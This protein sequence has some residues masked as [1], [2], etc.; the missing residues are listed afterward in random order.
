MS[1]GNNGRLDQSS[2]NL[3]D[4]AAKATQILVNAAT[5]ADWDYFEIFLGFGDDMLPA[6]Q[7]SAVPAQE[8]KVPEGGFGKMPSK[9]LSRTSN[10]A[11][12]IA[13]WQSVPVTES[14]LKRW[15]KDPRYSVC[16][17]TSALRAL[18]C[19]VTDPQL[20]LEIAECIDAHLPAA[21]KRTRSNSPK[22]LVPFLYKAA[23][24]KQVIKTAAGKIELLADG[25][26]FIAA[27]VHPSG[28]RYE[29][30]PMPREFPTL[31]SELLD[32]LW[33]ALA[34]RFGVKPARALVTHEG[35]SPP[36]SAARTTSLNIE[37]LRRAVFLH[38]A[39]CEHD[40]W[41]K[42]GMRLH[43][44][45]GG[46]EDGLTI[47]DAWSRTA[48]RKDKDGNLVY[49]GLDHLRAR[50]LSFSSEGKRAVKGEALIAQLPAEATEFPVVSATNDA[51]AQIGEVPRANHLCTDLANA[52]RIK[53]VFGKRLISV[54]GIFY[55]W[56]GTHWAR[57][58]GE[59]RRCAA[60][61]S[62]IVKSEARKAREKYEELLAS[63]VELVKKAEEH[64]RKHGLETTDIGRKLINTQKG[65]EALESWGVRCEFK[66]TQDQAIGLLRNM[67]TVEPSSLDRDPWA[68]NCANGTIDLRTGALR[69]HSQTDYIT[70]CA[71]VAFS[72]S[73]EAP[74]FNRFLSEI[75]DA[76]TARIAFL[77]RW[78]G[79]CATGDVR[80]QKLIVHVGPGGNGKSTLLQAVSNV[81]GE[82]AGTAAPGLL[83]GSGGTDRHPTEIADLYGRRLVTSHESD[84]GAMLRE[85]FIKQATGDDSL[86]GRLMR[87]DF[88]QFKPTHKFQLLTNYKPIVRGQDRGMWRRLLLV[89][90]LV[91]FGSEED[92][93]EGRAMQQRDTSL[94]V[95]LQHESEGILAWLVCGAVE[96]FRDGLRAPDSVLAASKDYQA[97]QDRIAQFVDEQCARDESAWFPF[98][99]PFGI[100]PLYSQWSKDNGYTP[101][102]KIRFIQE[103]ERVVPRFRRFELKRSE[104]GVRK[105]IRGAYGL[106]LSSSENDLVPPQPTANDEILI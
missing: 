8:S 11:V 78:F 6:V 101:L 70:R 13:G 1:A 27:G 100:Y 7:A 30:R 87:A 77:R 60:K 23:L 40:E 64:P 53:A 67:L 14:D 85:G 82:Y 69:P 81:L 57:D 80:E 26:Q 25:E 31:S 48:T 89:P 63:N 9:Y 91:S 45:A 18:D 58:E 34:M 49:K 95:T 104:E 20:A 84:D 61:L 79:Y 74:R 28:V 56:I 68:L 36:S 33:G 99:G 21:A 29:W 92:V 10:E 17:R 37:E 3:Q 55:A 5:A 15:R 4:D 54:G 47:W 94:S 106:R 2:Q 43:D 16:V 65:V 88:F 50:W 90:Y 96:W 75:M 93:K 98:D 39:N 51:A 44:G 83:A 62:A 103:L 46:A 52:N 19:D 42:I 41:L 86:K 102:G 76:D 35:Q 24:K 66:S 22:F 38:D 105:T 12:G 71:P 72:P 73:A 97:E 59:A 32:R